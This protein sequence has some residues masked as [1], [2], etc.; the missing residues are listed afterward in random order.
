[1]LAWP[2]HTD[3]QVFGFTSSQQLVPYLLRRVNY[4]SPQLSEE[5]IFTDEWASRVKGG[6]RVSLEEALTGVSLAPADLCSYLYLMEQHRRYTTASL[7]LFRQVVEVRLPFIDSALLRVLLRGRA[8]WRDDT[9]LHRALTRAG[10]PRL[11]T[12]RN[13]NTGAPG[14]A[15]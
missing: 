11:L 4:I 13:S 1:S 2:L 12:V 5:D 9:R 10:S 3:E 14:N 8:R 6:A 15:G 7:E